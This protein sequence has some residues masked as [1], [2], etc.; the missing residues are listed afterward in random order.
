MRHKHL[1]QDSAREVPVAAVWPNLAA[2]LAPP[3]PAN[4]DAHA[5]EVEPSVRSTAAP[6]VPASV[7][8]LIVASYLC[9]LGTFFALMAGSPLAFFSLVI[10]AGFMAIY[11]AVPRIFLAVEADPARRPTFQQFLAKGLQTFTGHSGGSDAIVQMLIVPV[12][13]TFGIGAMGI[14]GKVFIG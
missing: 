4:D 5:A 1:M 8:R 2:E 9:L 12:L 6:D 14:V 7:G 13:L 10:C 11:F 3:A